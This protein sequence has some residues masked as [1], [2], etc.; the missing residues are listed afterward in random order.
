M[1][2]CHRR[3]HARQVRRERPGAFRVRRRRFRKFRPRSIGRTRYRPPRGAALVRRAGVRDDPG[4]LRPAGTTSRPGAQSPCRRLHRPHRSGTKERS[5]RVRRHQ[6]P[7]NGGQPPLGRERRGPAH[8]ARRL[9]RRHAH[10]SR[11]TLLRSHGGRQAAE[12]R[13][14]HGGLHG[15]ND[16]ARPEKEYRPGALRPRGGPGKTLQALPRP[17]RPARANRGAVRSRRLP[18]AGRVLDRQPRRTLRLSAVGHVG[19]RQRG[20]VDPRGALHHGIRPRST[21]RMGRLR[22]G[23]DPRIR[24]ARHRRARREGHPAGDGHRRGGL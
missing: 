8:A 6:H 14:A 12:S 1:G 24:P 21:A 5:G 9:Q 15:A 7:A 16:G 18:P 2:T 19:Q 10:R 11:G 17:P 20:A 4:D 3:R 13:H 22:A 23:L